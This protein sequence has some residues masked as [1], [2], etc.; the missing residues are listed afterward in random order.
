[1]DLEYIINAAIAFISSLTGYFFGSRKN[2]A[3]TDSIVIDNVKEIL[4]VYN[5]TINDLKA[6]IMELREK[7][8]RYEKHIEKLQQELNAFRREMKPN[9]RKDR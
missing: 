1:M 8:D 5:T 4:G 6:E 3:E 2:N 9:D 7:I